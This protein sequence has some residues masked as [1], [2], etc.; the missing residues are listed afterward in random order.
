MK[1]TILW[2]IT[3]IGVLIMFWVGNLI[4]ESQSALQ[5]PQVRGQVVSSMLSIKHL[6]K[7]IDSNPGLTRWYGADVQYEYVVNDRPY[8]SKRV[9]FRDGES[10]NPKIALKVMNKYRRQ[11]EVMVYYDPINP[12]QA[13]LEPGYI[14]DIF[15]PL[16][17]G[18]LLLI[19]SLFIF[20]DQ[21]FEIN[22]HER[23]NHLYWGNAYQRKG[24]FAEA[25]NQFNQVILLSPNLIQGYKSRGNLYL[26]QGKWD[27]AIAD[28]S[29]AIVIDPTDAGVYF[30]RANAYLGKKEYYSAQLDMK[31]AMDK[32]FKVSPEILQE[33]KKGL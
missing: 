7:F 15:M 23:D 28:L 8:L 20:F 18:G 4:I 1:K 19:L 27:E 12:Q 17:A 22:I 31:M 24:K 14:G 6:P 3:V 32:G 9:S 5:W 21:S 10:R 30:N 16:A 13:V 11:D 29:K 26:Q 25:L 33:I 2:T